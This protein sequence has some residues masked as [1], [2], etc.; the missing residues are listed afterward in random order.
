MVVGGWYD[1][2]DLY[3]T[4]KTYRSIEKNNPGI[5]NTLVIGPWAHGGWIRT[6]GSSLGNVSFGNQTSPFYHDSIE[7]PFFNYYLKDKG[8]LN[9]PKAM[10][11]MTGK[12]EWRKLNKWPPENLETRK[13]Y[14]HSN[15]RLTFD[16]PQSSDSP[17]DEFISDPHKPV[18]YTEDIAFGMTK[19]YMT[20]DQRFAANLQACSCMDCFSMSA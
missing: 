14:F 13:L 10:M 7:L 9:L 18:P 4:F 6:D 1:A 19:E 3:G 11:F 5:N 17:F 2:E 20:D 12:N 15:A 8:T 16:A